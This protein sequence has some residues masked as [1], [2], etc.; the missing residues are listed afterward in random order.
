ML[1][2]EKGEKLLVPAEITEARRAAT[3]RKPRPCSAQTFLKLALELQA[4][5][6]ADKALSRAAL[7]RQARIT[8]TRLT[9]ILHLCRLSV[10]IRKAVLAL[11]PTVGRGLT[12]KRLRA[13]ALEPSLSSQARRFR[14]LLAGDR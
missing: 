5:L 11:G 4:K 7:A 14:L 8:P 2:A 13:V 12:E 9:Q 6:Q 10:E 1:N 3:E